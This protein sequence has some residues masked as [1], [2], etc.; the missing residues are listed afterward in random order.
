MLEALV[1]AFGD[2]F[3]EQVI[4]RLVGDAAGLAGLT[5]CVSVFLRS[6]ADPWP[7]TRA[8]Y[9]LLGE[10]LGATPELRPALAAYHRRL[11]GMIAAYIT[12]GIDAGEIDPTI[13][14]DAEAAAVVALVRGIGY[15]VL[16]DPDAFD[17]GELEGQVVG[18]LERRLAAPRR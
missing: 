16:S 6:L 9:V 5:R 18:G 14:A 11:R 10:S 7:M 3:S 2:R 13:D 8:L 1:V 15:Q 12:Q 4:H 17:L